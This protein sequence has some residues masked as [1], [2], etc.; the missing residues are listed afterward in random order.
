MRKRFVFLALI[1]LCSTSAVARVLHY[2]VRQ[3]Y[4]GEARPRAEVAWIWLDYGVYITDVDGSPVAR[5][6]A[7]A[8]KSEMHLC[9]NPLQLY[10]AE[11]LPGSHE[12]WVAYSAPPDYSKFK[13]PLKVDAKAG[14]NYEVQANFKVHFKGG[15]NWNPVIVPFAPDADHFQARTE[16]RF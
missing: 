3:L 13:L 9:G 12:I 10:L 4:S 1:V 7:P 16:C 11:L 2:N 8:S 15:N 5:P 6:Q 14:E